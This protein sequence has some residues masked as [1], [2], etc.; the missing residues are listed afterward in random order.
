MRSVRA[1]AAVAVASAVLSGCTPECIDKYDCK[2]F[3]TNGQQ[4]T[5]VN[6]HCEV[7]TPGGN[8]GGIE[9]T[10]G[11]SGTAGGA[12]A[13]GGT[14]GGATAGGATAGGSTAGGATAGGS[15]AGG[16]TAGGATA[17]GG[18][19]GGGSA[20]G[21]TAGGSAGGST[22]GGAPGFSGTYVAALSGNQQIPPVATPAAGS[23]T[24]TLSDP[25][26]G[27]YSLTWSVTHDAGLPMAAHLHNG[28]AGQNGP[29]IVD[30]LSGTSP[31]AGSAAVS[32]LTASRI[33]TGF[34][35][36]NVHTAAHVD[37]E[38]RGQLLKASQFIWT[39]QL[40]G[41]EVLPAPVVG[42]DAGTFGILIDPGSGTATYQGFWANTPAT[43][44][45]IYQGGPLGE[46]PLVQALNPNGAPGT[47]PITGL[48]LGDGGFYVQ[49]Q[50]AA[51]PAGE[52]R[53]QLTPKP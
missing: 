39:A 1:L 40:S 30:L 20:G 42:V 37:G 33:A 6:N 34:F 28:W 51:H 16:G 53:G 11:G 8:A 9:A 27:S 3:E 7:G 15:T 47:F 45:G 24:F 52:I 41:A 36:V 2:K 26:G 48:A 31:I 10:A 17:G 21:A 44:A 46:G 35:Y 5:C 14:A 38:L 4:F 32:N 29:V 13:G 23:A 12:T 50:T 19:A 22:A 49:V 18:S 25:D 43:D